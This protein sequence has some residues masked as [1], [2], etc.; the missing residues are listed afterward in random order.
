MLLLLRPCGWLRLETR[1]PMASNFVSH[2]RDVFHTC[3]ATDRTTLSR[4]CPLRCFAVLHCGHLDG[5][6]IICET[7]TSHRLDCDWPAIA[8][9]QPTIENGIGQRV[10]IHDMPCYFTIRPRCRDSIGIHGNPTS[11]FFCVENP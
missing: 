4:S 8:T 3:T 2:L 6:I 1:P 11:L 9:F 5:K 7:K 10:R